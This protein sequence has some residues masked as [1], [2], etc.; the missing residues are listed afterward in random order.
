ML[1]GGKRWIFR[2]LLSKCDILCDHN[3][4]PKLT[5][6]AFVQHLALIPIQSPKEKRGRSVL[7]HKYSVMYSVQTKVCCSKLPVSTWHVQHVQNVFLGG[8]H[9][10]ENLKHLTHRYRLM[11]KNEF[12]Q[13]IHLL[14]IHTCLAMLCYSYSIL[15]SPVSAK[16]SCDPWWLLWGATWVDFEKLATVSR[17]FLTR[18]CLNYINLTLY[19]HG[20]FCTRNL[21]LTRHAVTTWGGMWIALLY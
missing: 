12:A 8:C 10:N 16:N 13:N 19:A 5:F 3:S 20:Q 18:S 9:S 21:I 17:Q 6:G 4:F 7:L 1:W 2:V 15:C 14:R 11:F